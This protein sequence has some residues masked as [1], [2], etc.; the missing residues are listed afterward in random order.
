MLLCWLLPT[1]GLSLLFIPDPQWDYAS[2]CM[3]MTHPEVGVAAFTS[4]IRQIQLYFF[5]LV[6]STKLDTMLFFPAIV[7]LYTITIALVN[8]NA[9][10]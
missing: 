10:A 5:F 7:V 8:I 2:F 4:C 1:P 3:S 6:F 9:L